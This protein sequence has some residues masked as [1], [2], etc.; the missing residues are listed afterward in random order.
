MPVRSPV[1]PRSQGLRIVSSVARWKLQT[2][3]SRATAFP[4]HGEVLLA[5]GLTGGTSTASVT[6]IDAGTGAQ[7]HF[8]TLALAVHDAAGSFVHGSPFLFGGGSSA[9]SP[10]VQR[11]ARSRPAVVGRLPT[12][13]SDVAAASIARVVYLVGGYNGQ[14]WIRTVLSTRDGRSFTPVARLAVPVRYAAV[15]AVGGILWVFGGMTPHGLT[16]TVQRV[17]PTTGRAKVVAHLPMPL[18]GASAL[19][20]HGALLVCGGND[21]QH[22]LR[23]IYRFD[24]T[25]NALKR[26]GTLPRPDAFAAAAVVAGNGYLLGGENP[27][28]PTR[29]VQVIRVAP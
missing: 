20:V 29:R 22:A 12:A 23:T 6:A 7:R 3:L 4:W 16:A 11:I 24:P 9:S 2:P 27:N 25:S 8:A 1:A 13:R 17:D 28:L 26:V 19:V 5:G 10:E 15:A 14:R 18:L 21:G